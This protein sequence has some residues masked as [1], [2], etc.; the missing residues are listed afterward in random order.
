[1]RRMLAFVTVSLIGLT[2]ISTIATGLHRCA[3][4]DRADW[5]SESELSSQLETQGWQVRRMKVDGGCWEVYGT[6]PEGQRVEAYFHPVTGVVE[7]IA[8][9]GRVLYRADG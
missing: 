4:T 1:M 9:R 3:P 7:L 2:P 5:L 6:T 8:Q